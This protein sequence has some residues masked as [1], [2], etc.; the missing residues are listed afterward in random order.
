MALEPLVVRKLADKTAGGGAPWPSAG[1]RLESIP[2]LTRVSM[3]WV[4]EN[5]A[6]GWIRIEG[7]KI[8]HAPAGPP[9]RPWARSHTFITADRIIFDTV[10]G[11]V[12][13]DVVHNPGKYDDTSDPSGKR[14]DHFFELRRVS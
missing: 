12:V 3:R 13:Y 9:Q 14:V 2:N 5:R 1:V 7:E 6:D 11:E 10:D 8:V 4:D